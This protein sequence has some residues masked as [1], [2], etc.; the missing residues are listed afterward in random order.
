MRGGA[1]HRLKQVPGLRDA[2]SDLQLANPQIDLDID[3]DKAQALGVGFDAINA[4]I[5]TSLGSSYVND[6]PSR[7]RLQ[8]VVVQADAPTRMQPEDLLR[9]NA[10]NA[11]GRPVP[12]SAFASTR[13]I[14]GAMQTIRYNGYS[15]MRLGGSAA[16]GYSTGAAMAEM[17][18]LAAQLPPGL[19]Q[20]S[21]LRRARRSDSRPGSSR[22]GR[23]RTES[24][25]PAV[26]PRCPR[27]RPPVLA[28]SVA[29]AALLVRG[30]FLRQPCGQPLPAA[31]AAR[32]RATTKAPPPMTVISFILP[33]FLAAT[34]V[35][36]LL[37]RAI[38]SFSS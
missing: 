36:N 28:A 30:T 25:R 24:G 3:R 27:P 9:I 20:R 7:G 32:I 11:Q 37:V 23:P 17:E 2:N 13:W 34:S 8:R 5:S 31:H 38:F 35:A 22:P 15:A 18:Q 29:A 21:P 12:L 19:R 14:K 10:S 26:A 16:P 4:V 6:F 33:D 1:H